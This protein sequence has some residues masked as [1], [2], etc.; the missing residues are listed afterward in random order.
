MAAASHL[1]ATAQDA[2]LRICLINL[3][4]LSDCEQ[5]GI[6]LPGILPV[7][8]TVV[9][10][11]EGGDIVTCR[12]ARSSQHLLFVG[13]VFCCECGSADLEMCY[14]SKALGP[15]LCPICS[16]SMA[17]WGAPNGS[18]TRAPMTEQPVA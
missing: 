6:Y 4:T 13:P 14:A 12:V 10:I 2:L 1:Q 15:H 8:Y 11:P 16:Q 18:Q 5:I 17:E 3:S 9:Y 7:T